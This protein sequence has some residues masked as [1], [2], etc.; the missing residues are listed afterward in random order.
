MRAFHSL[1]LCQR[2]GYSL[3]TDEMPIDETYYGSDSGV[4]FT[5]SQIE[6]GEERICFVA[7]CCNYERILSEAWSCVKAG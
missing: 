1:M 7:S 2:P 3:L 5:L 4:G 6:S